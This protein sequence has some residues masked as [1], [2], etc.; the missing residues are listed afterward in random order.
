MPRF[1]PFRGLRYNTTRSIDV[2]D[3]TSPPYDVFD[4][5]TRNEYARLNEHNV[6]HVDYPL[7]RD[8]TD[9]YDTAAHLLRSWVDQG[10]L[11]VEDVPAFYIYRMTFTD[12]TLT[13]RTTVGVLG[14]LEVVDVEAGG[15]LP[16]E[17]TTPKAKTDRLDLTRATRVNLSPVWG[18]SL[19]T[20]LS[21][22]LEQP[23][24]E[25]AQSVD[26]Q[27]VVHL[28]E[29]IDDPDRLSR[30]SACVSQKP[31]LIAD[32]HHRYAISR[33]Y[34]DEMSGLAS[35]RGTD[36]TFTYVAELVEEQLSI[37]AIHRLYSSVSADELTKALAL[38]FTMSDAGLV[39]AS[40]LLEM[41]RQ[42]ALCL[43]DPTGHGT[44]LQPLDHAFEGV[45]DLDSARLEHALKDVPH[46][47]TYQ[48]GVSDVLVALGSERCSAA[49]LI[50]PVN[51]DQIRHVA[52]S[53]EL[54]P[55]KSTFFTPK[56]RTGLVMRPLDY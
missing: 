54:M 52:N 10:V 25:V 28:V 37:A 24:T 48:H 51:I 20:G 56:L 33:M 42:R 12:E 26:E 19:N 55:P 7:E 41:R 39:D 3:V 5:K 22:L 38:H 44:Y 46:A 1:E 30:I 36:L 45:R 32:G 35:S 16:H 8:G 50:R 11:V 13:T 6:V 40:T 47:V 29:R 27:G 2:S 49:I 43:V 18:L 9:R 17:Q 4:E 23:G 31:V 15:V 14:A 21:E 34:R 53:G